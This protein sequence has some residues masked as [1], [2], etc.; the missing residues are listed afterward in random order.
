MARA[1]SAVGLAPFLM[2]CSVAACSWHHG[3]WDAW[4]LP[5]CGGVMS[6]CAVGG[7]GN[8]AVCEQVPA[9]VCL[10][11]AV[12][13]SEA[14][15]PVLATV[16]ARARV[17]HGTSPISLAICLAGISPRCVQRRPD[18]G[19]MDPAAAVSTLGAGE[20]YRQPAIF[21]QNVRIRIKFCAC[22]PPTPTPIRGHPRPRT[23][24][25]AR[26]RSSIAGCSKH[27][28][29]PKQCNMHP[30]DADPHCQRAPGGQAG[31]TSNPTS[32]A[33]PPLASPRR[34]SGRQ[35]PPHT[36]GSSRA[37]YPLI[38]CQARP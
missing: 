36:R 27:D 7:G 24:H 20:T 10:T 37:P 16:A 17:R 11:L 1:G 22:L 29:A 25:T 35:A 9:N 28:S 34:C 3:P 38:L 8:A 4:H 5:G 6:L 21:C 32:S 18:R 12:L 31:P 14:F 33:A 2:L 23:V 15:L 13:R 26:V 30:H 19:E